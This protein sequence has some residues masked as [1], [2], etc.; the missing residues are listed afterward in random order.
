M[1]LQGSLSVESDVAE[2]KKQTESQDDKVEVMEEPSLSHRQCGEGL[3]L[4]EDAV[5]HRQKSLAVLV[6]RTNLVS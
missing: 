2:R 5:K 3:S 1:H 6:P 4:K